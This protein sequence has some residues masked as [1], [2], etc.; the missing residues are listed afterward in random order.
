[1][2]GNLQ[3]VSIN[4]TTGNFKP[5]DFL[6]EHAREIIA[7]GTIVEKKDG[8]GSFWEISE[9]VD[10]E[11]VDSIVRDDINGNRSCSCLW[12]QKS[13]KQ[14]S[15]IRCEHILALE[16]YLDALLPSNFPHEI[17]LNPNMSNGG[18][19][20]IKEWQYKMI[21]AL[22]R[23]MR[24]DIEALSMQIYGCWIDELSNSAADRFI[25]HLKNMQIQIREVAA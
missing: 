3:S 2:Q 21:K 7:K 16:I 13:I 25:A 15:R 10:G 14:K 5:L 19:D 24:E 11:L 1:M 4:L 22:G 17:A 6:Q 20:S 12:F 8:H 9:M 18:E 23:G